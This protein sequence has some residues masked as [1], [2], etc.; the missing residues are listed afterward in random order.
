MCTC[1]VTII[2]VGKGTS[3]SDVLS[4]SIQVLDE[5]EDVKHQ[6]TPMSTQL[7]GPTERIMQAIQAMHEAAFESGV[8]RV[9]TTIVLDE[10]RDKDLS[11]EERVEHVKQKV[12]A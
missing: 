2:P 6:I 11:L 9:Y 7:E 5:F 8:D 1:S 4:K 10:R 3:M 12:P